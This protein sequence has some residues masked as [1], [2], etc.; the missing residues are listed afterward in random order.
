MKSCLSLKQGLLQDL[1]QAAEHSMEEQRIGEIFYGIVIICGGCQLMFFSDHEYR[2]ITLSCTL[3]TAPITSE[4]V[5]LLL[6]PQSTRKSPKRWRSWE[7]PQLVEDL[8]WAPF[9][10]NPCSAFS[11]IPCSFRLAP[12]SCLCKPELTGVSTGATEIYTWESS[13]QRK[14]HPSHSKAQ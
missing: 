11:S 4:P 6:K 12:A 14:A 13:R 5:T 1:E 3:N 10:S 7:I 2:R 8:I 9:L